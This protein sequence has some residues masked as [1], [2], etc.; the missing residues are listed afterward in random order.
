MRDHAPWHVP[1]GGPPRP[2]IPAQIASAGPVRPPV[3][4]AAAF[5]CSFGSVGTVA[6]DVE[7]DVCG[8]FVPAG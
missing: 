1:A 6:G 7:V 2:S 8:E 3:G 4:V 5:V